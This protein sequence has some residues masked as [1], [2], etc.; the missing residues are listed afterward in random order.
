MHDKH[1][2]LGLNMRLFRKPRRQRSEFQDPVFGKIVFE[3]GVWSSVPRAGSNEFMLTIVA[4]VTGP[5]EQHRQLGNKLLCN[6]AALKNAALEFMKSRGFS[7]SYLSSLAIYSVEV[8]TGEDLLNEAFTLEL[9]DDSATIIH[10]VS[11]RLGHP[12]TYECDD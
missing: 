4:P 1:L 2:N 5:S 8:G 9:S 7:S 3:H 12:V 10:R 11:F 6:L